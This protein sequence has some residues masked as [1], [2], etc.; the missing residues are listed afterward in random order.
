[1]K[2]LIDK[3]VVITKIENLKN[4]A[5][6]YPSDFYC[7]RLS[8]CNELMNF[9]DTLEAKDVD[10]ELEITLWANA[11]PEV[12]LDDVER[13][14]KYFFELGLKVQEGEEQ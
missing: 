8:I 14:A 10:L 1:M 3:S 11:I 5:K 4:D 2:H 12:R 7:G 9:L 13:L 6:I